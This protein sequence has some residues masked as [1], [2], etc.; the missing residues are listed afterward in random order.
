MKSKAFNKF[1]DL[2]HNLLYPHVINNAFFKDL[3]KRLNIFVSQEKRATLIKQK[4]EY[5]FLNFDI[6]GYEIIVDDKIDKIRISKNKK[7]YFPYKNE[8]INFFDAIFAISEIITK[9]FLN[10]SKK[11]DSEFAS[12]YFNTLKK[13]YKIEDNL[14]EE[15]Y[16]IIK[17]K[18][19]QISIIYDNFVNM[20]AWEEI[21]KKHNF[22]LT[23][24]KEDKEN[25]EILR[26]TFENDEYEII[27]CYL[28]NKKV[29]AFEIKK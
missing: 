23:D 8:E 21:I 15:F 9:D 11:Y 4:I 5:I 13:V 18:K 7:V 19:I 25:P 1:Y 3:K 17:I 28:K 12:V 16:E 10:K 29:K 27:V 26:Y 24:A 22:K 20:H 6:N 2:S 14:I